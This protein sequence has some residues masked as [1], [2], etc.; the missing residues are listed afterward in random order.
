MKDSQ[1]LTMLNLS[2][3]HYYLW[4]NQTAEFHLCIRGEPRNVICS[5]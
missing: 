4:F 5:L 1:V 2:I 3:Y